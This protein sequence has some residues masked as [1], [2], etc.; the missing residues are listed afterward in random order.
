MRSESWVSTSK[1]CIFSV[2]HIRFIFFAFCI[3]LEVFLWLLF[4]GFLKSNNNKKIIRL[5]VSA[6][7]NRL[8]GFFMLPW[9]CA[10]HQSD[11]QV[12]W[13]VRWNI[14]TLWQE[15]I[16]LHTL[17]TY[18]LCLG[19]GATFLFSRVLICCLW[20]GEIS[21]THAI[22]MWLRIRPSSHPF[23][24]RFH[25]W[26]VWLSNGNDKSCVD[27]FYFSGW[28]PTWG[29]IA[30]SICDGYWRWYGDR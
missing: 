29:R 4:C 3:F 13:W 8:G 27:T 22:R 9:W 10:P 19:F 6:S 24:H 15:T 23:I 7:V 2:L 21:E 26:C 18:K 11:R 1:L 28:S 16:Y 5:E 17:K 14:C 20:L 30:C 12:M 25:F